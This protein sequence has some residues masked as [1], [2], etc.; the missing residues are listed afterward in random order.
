MLTT[1]LGIEVMALEMW[2]DTLDRWYINNV[3][4]PRKF[5]MMFWAMY[6]DMA[7]CD[8]LNSDIV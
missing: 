2:F 7:E 5:K 6:N 4:Q 1:Y 3:Q 8:S